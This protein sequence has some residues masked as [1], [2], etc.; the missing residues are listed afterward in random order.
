VPVHLTATV[1]PAA[2]YILTQEPRLS[3]QSVTVSGARSLIAQI[4][5]I[6]TRADSVTG[7]KWNNS[8]PLALDMR[9]I[10]SYIDVA[11]TLVRL[12]VRVDAISR[13]VFTGVPVHLIGVYDTDKYSLSPA[14]ATLEVSGGKHNLDSLLMADIG[15][16]IEFSRFEIEDADSLAP[17]VKLP[18]TVQDW[19]VLPATFKLERN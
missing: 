10:S 14:T 13:R 5:N 9:G 6:P 16:Y 17:T 15:L 19:R 3:P 8:I 18:E 7:L 12:E 11:D 2:G 1:A 4:R